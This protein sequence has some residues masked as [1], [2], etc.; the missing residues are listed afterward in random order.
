M[1][2]GFSTNIYD[3]CKHSII[4]KSKSERKNDCDFQLHRLCKM[5][6][7]FLLVG[8]ATILTTSLQISADSRLYLSRSRGSQKLRKIVLSI[9]RKDR[10]CER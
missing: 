7:L 2:D 6:Q 9:E 5:I 8:L 10:P 1:K 3:E 4:K